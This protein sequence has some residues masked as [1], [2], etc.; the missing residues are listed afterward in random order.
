MAFVQSGD[1]LAG[2][3]FAALDLPAEQQAKLWAALDTALTDVF[4][5]LLLGLDG[6]AQV[7]GVQEIFR[8]HD[9]EGN[10]ISDCGELEAEAYEQFQA[11]A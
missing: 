4:Y 2:K 8:I 1:G 10:L 9:E 11:K 5:T 6:C 7:G 3:Q